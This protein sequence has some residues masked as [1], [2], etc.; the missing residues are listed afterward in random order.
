M[1]YKARKKKRN[2]TP[3]KP[4]RVR[5]PIRK[6]KKDRLAPPAAPVTKAELEDEELEEGEIKET[7]PTSPHPPPPSLDI[8]DGEILPPGPSGFSNPIN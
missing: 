8:Q 2:C 3:Q 6:I 7:P 4:E 5:S 1:K